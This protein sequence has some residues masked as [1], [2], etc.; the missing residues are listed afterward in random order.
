MKYK[1]NDIKEQLC[2]KI[3]DIIDKYGQEEIAVIG[4]VEEES[5]F[6]FWGKKVIDKEQK[7]NS[8]VTKSISDYNTYKKEL[9]FSNAKRIK[10]SIKDEYQVII[11]ITKIDLS[12]YSLKEIL[13]V[14]K[15]V[16]K[17]IDSFKNDVKKA[18]N[19]IKGG[20]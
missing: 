14:Y 16:E 7:I 17:L 9:Y 8:V 5:H 12:E 3:V 13:Q 18:K 10:N 6:N 15:K 1:E 2:K 20:K 4:Y 11:I 19:I